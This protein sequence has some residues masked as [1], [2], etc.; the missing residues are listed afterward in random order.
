MTTY[1]Y[2]LLIL[3][4]STAALPET[5][6][7]PGTGEAFA[8]YVENDTRSLGGPGSD[9]AYTNGLKFSYIYAEDKIPN[10]VENATRRLNLLDKKR[11]DTTSN[12]G[13]SLG[14][15]IYTPNNIGSNQFIPKDRPYAGWLYLGLAANFKE[16]TVAHF[17]ELDVGMVG[18]S[19]LGKQ[20]QNN[21]HDLIGKYRAQGWQYGLRDEP[22]LQ[23]SYQKRHKVYKTQII[24]ILPYYGA[25]IGN[26]LLGA[27]I[28]GLIRVGN[29]VLEDFGPSRPSSS[30]GDSF[31]SPINPDQPFKP[32]YY[33]FFGLRGNV[34]ARSIFIDGNTF[35]PSH[36]V[37]R[38]PLVF[39]TEVGFGVQVMPFSLVWRFVTR[40]PEFEERKVFIS[41][42]SINLVYFL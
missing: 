11:E 34:V 26:V 5:K 24:D 9:Q 21:W 35:K 39:D 27:H 22:T 15:Q 6:K 13:M 4:L 1:F 33:G 40:S 28:G 32:S 18:P 42:A 17:F 14:H 23:F 2:F 41:F 20:V 3:F 29:H 38:V 7:E 30:D 10:W 8:F 37:T 12:L 19:A 36:H 31:I 16:D 25:V